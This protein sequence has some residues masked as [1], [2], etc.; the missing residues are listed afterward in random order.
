MSGENLFYGVCQQAK[1][2]CSWDL[3]KDRIEYIDEDT[4]VSKLADVS[5]ISAVGL[6]DMIL[7]PSM[8]ATDENPNISRKH[9]F[10]SFSTRK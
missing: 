9:L 4:Y 3:T 10:H 2:Y 5:L 7:T 8:V 6:D 1:V